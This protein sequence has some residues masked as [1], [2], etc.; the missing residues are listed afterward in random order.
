MTHIIKTVLDGNSFEH[1]LSL[2]QIQ[3]PDISAMLRLLEKS[4]HG[5]FEARNGLV[6]RKKGDTIL[7]WVPKAMYSSVIKT[8]HDN[9]GHV[10]VDKTRDLIS[11]TY[12]FPKIRNEIKRY[13]SNCLK[14][15]TY[16]P[17]SGKPEGF[18]HSIPKE[19]IPFRTIHIDQRLPK[20][21][22]ARKFRW[23]AEKCGIYLLITLSY[24]LRCI[25][26]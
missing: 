7:F 12:W 17:N 23:S 19:P 5:L 18:L 26:T 4:E 10:G 20:W 8:Y 11:P 25:K 24:V 9:V 21:W 22:S 15:I 13:I 16:S 2:K 14:C 1:T 3:D 6:Y